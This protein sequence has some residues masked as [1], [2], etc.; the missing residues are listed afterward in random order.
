MIRIEFRYNEIEEDF[1][2]LVGDYEYHGCE[3]GVRAACKVFGFDIMEMDS[4]AL[5]VREVIPPK[6]TVTVAIEDVMVRLNSTN[7]DRST[8]FFYEHIGMLPKAGFYTAEFEEM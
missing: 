6:A 2:I 7:E 8:S 1:D 5:T 3:P 4:F